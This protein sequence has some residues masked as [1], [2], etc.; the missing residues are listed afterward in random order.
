MCGCLCRPEN[1]DVVVVSREDD[2]IIMTLAREDSFKDSEM[3]FG[4]GAS[5]QGSIQS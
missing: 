2:L 3:H 4:F 1:A 5:E